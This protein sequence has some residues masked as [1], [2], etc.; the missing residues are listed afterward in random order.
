MKSLPSVFS[1]N[2]NSPRLDLCTWPEIEEYLKNLS[3]R[4]IYYLKKFLGYSYKN[5]IPPI[6][7]E[8]IEALIKFNQAYELYKSH[9]NVIDLKSQSCFQYILPYHLELNKHQ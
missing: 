1:E 2:L 6:S 8:D 9:L 7:K 3:A 4:D 5:C